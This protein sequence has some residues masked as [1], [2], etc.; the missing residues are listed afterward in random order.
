MRKLGGKFSVKKA[1]IDLFKSCK[2][3]GMVTDHV[4]ATAA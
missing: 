2:L 3:E 1:I 4:C